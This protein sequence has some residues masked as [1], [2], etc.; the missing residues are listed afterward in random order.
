MFRLQTRSRSCAGC[1]MCCQ[2]WLTG[3]AYGHR[4]APGRPCGWLNKS[5]CTIYENRPYSPCQTF[6]CEWKRRSSIDPSLRPDLVG[7]I[8]ISRMHGVHEYIRVIESRGS[9]PDRVH[10]WAQSYSNEQAVNIVVPVTG[11]MR[12]YSR[13]DDFRRDI[14]A[15]Y[16]VVAGI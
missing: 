8:M 3:E 15:V 10:E 1:T 11:G 16:T 5:G 12:V 4:F 9:V 2:G 14:A 6:E 13:N 7:V